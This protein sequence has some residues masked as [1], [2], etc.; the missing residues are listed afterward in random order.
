MN[1]REKV[2]EPKVPHSLRRLGEARRRFQKERDRG[3]NFK[4]EALS[5]VGGVYLEALLLR[6]LL[7]LRP[8]TA[9][10]NGLPDGNF[11]SIR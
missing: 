7:K 8:R 1:C 2:S 4:I 5:V 11:M 6:W 3:R 10:T 9:C